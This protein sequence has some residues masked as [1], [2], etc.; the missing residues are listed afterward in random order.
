MNNEKLALFRE[1]YE[2][3]LAE[4]IAAHPN[5]YRIKDAALIAE[6]AIGM[7]SLHGVRSLT[8]TPTTK[9][10]AKQFGIANTYTAWEAWFNA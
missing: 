2:A 4:N 5:Q 9:A 3:K 10:L 1:R 8:L 6:R 7:I